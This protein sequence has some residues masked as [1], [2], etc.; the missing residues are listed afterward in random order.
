MKK[1]LLVP[2]IITTLFSLTAQAGKNLKA[3]CDAQQQVYN[4]KVRILQIN[5]FDYDK[6]NVPPRYSIE[7]AI[8]YIDDSF[9]YFFY[10]DATTG[11]HV[12]QM[13]QVAKML[14]QPVNVCFD[15]AKLQLLGIEFS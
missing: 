2:L 12:G 9:K 11:G 1:Y 7:F 13:A 4:T 3:D 5:A 10:V 8:N 6:D 14:D 15:F